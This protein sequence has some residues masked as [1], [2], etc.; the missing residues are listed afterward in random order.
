MVPQMRDSNRFL[1]KH[2]RSV[3]RFGTKAV[4]FMENG[5]KCGLIFGKMLLYKKKRNVA[6]LQLKACF[7]ALQYILAS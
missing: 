2:A 7:K 1:Q 4:A 5:M 3:S 6:K